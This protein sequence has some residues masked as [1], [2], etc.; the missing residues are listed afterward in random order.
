MQ[1]FFKIAEG[2]DVEPLRLA[3]ERQPELFGRN[4]ER[5][6]A[7]GSPHQ[8]MSDI[9]LRYN[10]R[11]PFDAGERPWSEFND[12]HDAI[13]YPEA[14]HLPE[15]RPIIFDIL[16]LVEAEHLGGVLITKL[17]PG[18]TIAPHVDSGWHAEAH[19]KFYVAV[20][21]DEGS[22]FGFPDGEI[23][24]KQGDVFCFRNNVPHWV[25]NDS[26][27]DRLSMIVCARL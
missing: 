24:A 8:V 3:L 1:N 12:R 22:V 26:A 20:Q 17:P 10:D 21:N 19:Q 7:E 27:R 23:R 4:G 16:R 18:G 25:N 14:A 13:W 5:K 15:A 11:A 2:V 9:W 6:Y